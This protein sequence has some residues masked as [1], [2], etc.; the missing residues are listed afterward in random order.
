MNIIGV[1]QKGSFLIFRP[2]LE[3]FAIFKKITLASHLQRAV[4]LPKL[5]DYLTDYRN[6]EQVIA[7]DDEMNEENLNATI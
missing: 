1:R 5:R 6:I 4:D 2:H 7:V 3:I